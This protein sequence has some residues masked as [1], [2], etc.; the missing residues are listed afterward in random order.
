MLFLRTYLGSSSADYV[1][2][3][4][5]VVEQFGPPGREVG[6][7]L[8]LGRQGI[9]AGPRRPA[10]MSITVSPGRLPVPSLTS[11]VPMLARSPWCSRTRG[12]SIQRPRPSSILMAPRRQIAQPSAH[13]DACQVDQK[14]CTCKTPRAWRGSCYRVGRLPWGGAR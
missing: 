7:L 2:Q 8:C 9:E 10:M 3:P 12:S 11:T 13:H 6:P 4:A 1:A 14:I 5:E